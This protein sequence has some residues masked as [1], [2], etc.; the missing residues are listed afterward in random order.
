MLSFLAYLVSAAVLVAALLRLELQRQQ[1][2]ATQPT[3][4]LGSLPAGVL[5][6]ATESEFARV[7]LPAAKP[8]CIVFRDPVPPVCEEKI[9]ANRVRGGDY[10]TLR[11]LWSRGSDKNL[12]V[13]PDGKVAT[14]D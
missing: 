2:A 8:V 5:M 13:H 14:L 11:M 7:E 1:T 6:V 3:V 10:R 4:Q 12:Q 9:T